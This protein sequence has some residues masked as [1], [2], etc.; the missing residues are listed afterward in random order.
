MSTGN[1]DEI[2]LSRVRG[3]GISEPLDA[4]MNDDS[5]D[6]NNDIM[7]R[8]G[9]SEAIDPKKRTF[10]FGPDPDGVDGVNDAENVKTAGMADIAAETTERLEDSDDKPPD[11]GFKAYSVLVGS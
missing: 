8:T 1:S 9:I 5:I 4:T 10:T 11:G 7:V 2:E 3:A 6:E